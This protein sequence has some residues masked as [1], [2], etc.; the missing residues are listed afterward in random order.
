MKIRLARIIGIPVPEQFQKDW[1]PIVHE[2][3]KEYNDQYPDDIIEHV[4]PCIDYFTH[5][6]DN[7]NKNLKNIYWEEADGMAD[8]ELINSNM[9]TYYMP[10]L[11]TY[12]DPN[13]RG[14]W[15]GE[16]WK[17]T[18]NLNDYKE[19]LKDYL[20]DNFDYEKYYG[21]YSMTEF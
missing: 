12:Q 17:C 13:I 9:E 7:I 6:Q 18:A 15:F 1:Q 16:K 3:I 4:E 5:N 21:E 14:I 11:D 2:W 20:P 8:I 19:Q 10:D